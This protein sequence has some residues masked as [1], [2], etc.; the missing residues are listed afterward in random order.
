[1]GQ[2]LAHISDFPI[3]ELHL[4]DGDHLSIRLNQGHNLPGVAHGDRIPVQPIVRAQF[5]HLVTVVK[6]GLEN[7]H[8]L[9]GDLGAFYAA[10]EF[11]S[12]P[13]EHTAADKFDPAA[14]VAMIHGLPPNRKGR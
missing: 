9:A 2:F 10:N 6:C 1:M 13:A 14:V 11:L 5:F 12:L 4:V 8:F 7:L 3:K